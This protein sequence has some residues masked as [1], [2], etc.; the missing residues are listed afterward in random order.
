MCTHKCNNNHI[1][2]ISSRFR[3]SGR[4]HWVHEICL[5][6]D[7]NGQ[8]RRV[9]KQQNVAKVSQ[10]MPVTK[11]NDKWYCNWTTND[12][13]CCVIVRSA[14][15]VLQRIIQNFKRKKGRSGFC[16][17]KFVLIFLWFDVWIHLWPPRSLLRQGAQLLFN[18][19]PKIKTRT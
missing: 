6:C 10:L 2:E 1:V 11:H 9:K 14:D 8:W 12:D 16:Y 7:L 15:V 5:L 19:H 13:F 3:Q 4:S 17:D 18:E